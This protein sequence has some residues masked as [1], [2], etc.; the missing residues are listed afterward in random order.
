MGVLNEKRCKN[1]A[2]LNFGTGDFTIEWYQY[3]TDENS[4]PR[5]FEMGYFDDDNISIGVSIEGG[6]FFYW[7]N[8]SS[9]GIAY[10]EPTEYKNQ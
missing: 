1:T 3:Q 6:T 7:T 4:F 9:N 2:D 5:I 10:F 8:T